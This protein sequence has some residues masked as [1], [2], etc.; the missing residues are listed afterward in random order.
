MFTHA[1]ALGNGWTGDQLRGGCR[2]GELVRVRR[3]VY[4]VPPP[5][6]ADAF[7][8]RRAA[9]LSAGVAAAL[10]VS[11]AVVSHLSA[12]AML[13]ISCLGWGGSR[14]SIT[15][16]PRRMGGVG[17]VLVHRAALPAA[18]VHQWDD[19]V[20][21]T[22]PARTVT[23]LARAEGVLAGVTAMD[24]ALHLRLTTAADIAAVID[25][26]SGWSGLARARRAATLADARAESVLESLSRLQIARVGLPPPQLQREI[27]GAD[28]RF[29]ARA[30]F[31]WDTEGIVGEADGLLKYTDPTVL[32]REKLR[33]EAIE[34]LGLTVL[35]WGWP[36]VWEFERVAARWHRAAARAR[37]LSHANGRSAP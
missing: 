20:L 23:D 5:E 34:Q 24:S 1:Q 14:P 25:E 28:G 33:Q 11:D 18:H 10:T 35:R 8:A 37:R 12:A 32:T 16:P 13:E 27:V 19:G 7:Q 6:T 9:F 26:C 30:D 15:V 4:C 3:G 17:G 29:I 36:D 31:Y 21:V 2:S 22:S